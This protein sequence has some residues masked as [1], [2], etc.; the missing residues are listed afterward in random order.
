MRRFVISGTRSKRRRKSHVGY[1]ATRAMIRDFARDGNG[2]SANGV[3]PA[4]KV[5]NDILIASRITFDGT[6][7][8][9]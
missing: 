7:V 2:V 3:P 6:N 1:L 8:K 5:V 9:I 4:V